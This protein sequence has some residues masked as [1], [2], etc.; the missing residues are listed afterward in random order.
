MS[1]EHG[2]PSSP[3]VLSKLRIVT[4]FLIA[5]LANTGVITMISNAWNFQMM[6]PSGFQEVGRLAY[7]F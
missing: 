6:G 5:P 4:P 1:H 3:V 2:A 7:E